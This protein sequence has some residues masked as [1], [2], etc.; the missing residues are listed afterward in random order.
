LW[1]KNINFFYLKLF[2]IILHRF[3]VLYQNDIL[4]NKKYYF[5]III[6]KKIPDKLK[7]SLQFKISRSLHSLLFYA[8]PIN[9]FFLLFLLLF[10]IYYCKLIRII[11]ARVPGLTHPCGHDSRHHSHSCQPP[12]NSCQF[13]FYCSFPN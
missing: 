3:N 4:K 8:H 7:I 6:N 11:I 10:S 9:F 13:F 5:N 1:L 2:F 12:G